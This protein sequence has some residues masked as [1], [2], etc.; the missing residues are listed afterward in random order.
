MWIYLE[1][2]IIYVIEI[3][4]LASITFITLHYEV[5]VPNGD[6]SIAFT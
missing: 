6:E 5:V 3:A 4:Q 2:S 1:I